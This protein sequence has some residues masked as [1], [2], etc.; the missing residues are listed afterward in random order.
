MNLGASPAEV[1][2]TQ[3]ARAL[4]FRSAGTCELRPEALA[5]P[6][7]G[8]VLVRTLFSGISRGTE[9]LVFNGR[10]PASE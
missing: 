10:V 8:T 2:R 1:A 4:W 3:I 5:E 9:N 7:P 6:P